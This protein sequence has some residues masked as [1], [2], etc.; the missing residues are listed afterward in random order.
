VSTLGD[1][2]EG[3]FSRLAHEVRTP[4]AV[5]VGYAELLAHR[6]DEETRRQA[7]VRILEAAEVLS[8]VVDDLLTLIAIESGT[9]VVDAVQLDLAAAVEVALAG[10]GLTVAADGPRPLVHA[11]PEHVARIVRNLAR[12]A[13][14]GGDLRVSVSRDGGF[15]V[16]SIAQDRA[17]GIELRTARRLVELQGGS[18]SVAGERLAFTLPLAPES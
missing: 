11:D 1:F 14:E 12:L 3:A 7:P 15:A 8:N 18:L 10:T 6:D 16:T 2:D 5:V 4:L 9:L 17:A 13:P